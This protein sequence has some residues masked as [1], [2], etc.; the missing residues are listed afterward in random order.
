MENRKK[1]ITVNEI[2]NNLITEESEI[3]SYVASEEFGIL[4]H[5]IPDKSLIIVDKNA[6]YEKGDF[7]IIKDKRMSEKGV[8]ITKAISEK[9]KDYLGKIILTMKKY[10]KG[11]W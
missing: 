2:L 9:E 6:K 1:Y 5:E 10:D 8:R 7:I 11:E 4:P 3:G